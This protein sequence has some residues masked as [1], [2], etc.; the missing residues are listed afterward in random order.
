MINTIYNSLEPEE[1]SDVSLEPSE[2]RH[3]YFAADSW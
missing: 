2:M 1:I 3:D